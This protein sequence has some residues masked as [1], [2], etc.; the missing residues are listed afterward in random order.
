MEEEYSQQ[1]RSMERFFEQYF[2]VEF[3]GKAFEKKYQVCLCLEIANAATDANPNYSCRENP[4]SFEDAKWKDLETLSH[5][6]KNVFRRF[7]YST[8]NPLQKCTNKTK[9]NVGIQIKFR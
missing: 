3:I 8:T 7:K 5:V 6:S 1:M 4:T 9:F 2:F